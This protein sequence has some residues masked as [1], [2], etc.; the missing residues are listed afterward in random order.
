M[1]KSPILLKEKRV[2]GNVNKVYNKFRHHNA[3]AI[4]IHLYVDGEHYL[5]TQ[6]QLYVAKKRA[7]RNQED[8]VEYKP[9][10]FVRFWRWLTNK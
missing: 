6:H 9:N 7:K 4:Y 2:K 3:N 5:F 1:N 10:W 8:L